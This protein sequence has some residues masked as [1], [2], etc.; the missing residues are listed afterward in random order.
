MIMNDYTVENAQKDLNYLLS[1]SC[2]V[3][4][5]GSLATHYDLKKIAYAIDNL[6]GIHGFVPTQNI[7]AI[8]DYA[9]LMYDEHFDLI[10]HKVDSE[11]LKK[12]VKNGLG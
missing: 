2:D 1:F 4:A 3:I 5:S 7:G 8:K 12:V 6:F 11:F 10:R 9:E